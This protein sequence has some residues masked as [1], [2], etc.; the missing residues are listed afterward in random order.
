M[1]YLGEIYYYYYFKISSFWNILFSSAV[2]NSSIITIITD[3]TIVLQSFSISIYSIIINIYLNNIYPILMYM[4][5]FIF[6]Q[7][8][9]IIDHAN[10]DIS[11][12]LN[13]SVE[14]PWEIFNSVYFIVF[15]NIAY[16]SH[17]TVMGYMMKSFK[18]WDKD[19][20]NSR[21]LFNNNNI[22]EKKKAIIMIL[23]NKSKINIH[24]KL[25][26]FII[27]RFRSKLA[28]FPILL[29]RIC[30]LFLS[31]Y[32]YYYYISW[33]SMIPLLLWIY[34]GFMVCL[35]Y[36]GFIFIQEKTI[37]IHSE[38][39]SVILMSLIV[40]FN[41]LSDPKAFFKVFLIVLF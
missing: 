4:K 19:I 2:I 27:M 1:S 37:C 18:V 36:Y 35:P 3:I 28:L 14:N 25:N 7:C 39:K 5:I 10:Y 6:N 22:E 20:N 12:V 9:I 33:I 15:L 30:Q 11:S 8:N 23:S 41:K 29:L 38:L 26:W 31:N 40:F 17:D 34:I 21:I 16:I 13:P 24:D 32:N